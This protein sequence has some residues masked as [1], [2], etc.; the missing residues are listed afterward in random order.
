[1]LSLR[2]LLYAWTFVASLP[3]FNNDLL[4]VASPHMTGMEWLKGAGMIA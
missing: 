1:M 4:S 2:R 3:H